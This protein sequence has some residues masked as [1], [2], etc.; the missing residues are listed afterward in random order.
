MQDLVPF[1]VIHVG[2]SIALAA[3][4]ILIHRRLYKADYL[5]YWAFFWISIA[6]NLALS[7]VGV[8]ALSHISGAPR[9]LASLTVA[10][11]PTYPVFMICAGLSLGGGLSKRAAWRWIAVAGALGVAA[12]V[13]DHLR[14]SNT[15]LLAQYRP[16][17][18]GLAVAFFAHRL[19]IKGQPEVGGTRTALVVLSLLYSLHNLALGSSVF[20]LRWSIYPPA[21]YSPQAAA[22]GILLQFGLT[23]VFSYGAI[24]RALQASRAAQESDR[25][26]RSLLESVGLAGLL[27][28]RAGRV[29]FCNQWLAEALGQP[30]AAMAGRPWLETFVPESERE[31]VKQVFKAGL[32][33]GTWPAIHEYPIRSGDHEE[34]LLQWYH[35][36]LL[37]AAGAVTGAASLGLDLT[38]HRR[39]EEQIRQSQKLEGIGRLAG[40]VAHDFNNLLTVVLGY[41]EQLRQGLPAGDERRDQLEEIHKAGMRAAALTQQLL[42][43]GRKQVLDQRVIRLNDVVRESEK[44][45]RRLIRE[46][47]ELVFR[48]DPEVGRVFV[49]S[50]Q[51]HQVILNLVVNAQ[52]A[53]LEGGRL[54]V[55]TSSA[56]W[57]DDPETP[58]GRYAVLAVTDTGH[59][60]DAQTRQ[61][62]FEPFF[63]TKGDLGTG[64]GLATVYGI[65]KQSGG[66]IAVDT[67]LGQGATFK[68]FLPQAGAGVA[69]DKTEAPSVPSLRGSETVLLVED[70]ELV[71]RFVAASLK[72]HGYRVLEAS[73]DDE[74]REL[75]QAHGRAIDL[76]LTDVVMPGLSG[77]KLAEEFQGIRPG[78]KVLFMSGY[79]DQTLA[80]YLEGTPG[81]AYLAKPFGTA[82]L[83]LKVR[84]VIDA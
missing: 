71:R 1:A 81:A 80:S 21:T 23:I 8:P 26:L 58:A 73:R 17:L 63:T 22:V 61:Q 39:L 25:R 78:L 19:A 9:L 11:T 37:D 40:G 48:L 47:I 16:V 28:D 18:T 15:T 74:A 27:L 29:E 68:V 67:A 56:D 2:V 45:L 50:G 46:D 69:A 55:E 33:S 51:L 77:P 35:T 72:H 34:L 12:G 32:E 54:L 70:Q 76:L 41:S 60:M 64:L 42:A 13:F 30:A 82:A 79:A 3:I 5:L 62:I 84:E 38:R 14:A 24:E 49:D 52:D 53:M 4:L 44:M 10:L 66:H 43:F 75:L 65:V 57:S 83:A 20:G 31:R 6:V 59:G 7:R 36:S